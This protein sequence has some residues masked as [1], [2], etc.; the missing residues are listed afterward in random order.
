[1]SALLIKRPNKLPLIWPDPQDFSFAF[2]DLALLL[3]NQN[4]N[5]QAL[6]NAVQFP[7]LDIQAG[8]FVRE[9]LFAL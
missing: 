8:S 3:R 4:S 7:V 1:M 9:D 6:E 2:E 5:K